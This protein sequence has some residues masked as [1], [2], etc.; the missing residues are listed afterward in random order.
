MS[1]DRPT[2]YEIKTDIENDFGSLFSFPTPLLPNS[3]AKSIA[4]IMTG[5]THMQYGYID[6]LAK[7]ALI[8]TATTKYLDQWGSIWAVVRNPASYAKGEVELTGVPFSICPA[9]TEFMREDGV[10]YTTDNL[11]SIGAGGTALTD[12]TCVDAGETGNM[13]ADTELTI[14]VSIPTLTDIAVVQEDVNSGAKEETD[15]A[16]RARI[17]NRVQETPQGGNKNDFE[18]WALTIDGVTRAFVFEN[19]NGAG[20]VGVT[21]VL[22]NESSIIPDS[23]KVDEVTDYIE[24]RRPLTCQVNVYAPVLKTQDLEIDLFP[25]TVEV[26]Q[27]VEAEI[28]DLFLR[29]GGAGEVIKIT[30]LNAAISTAIGEKDHNLHLTGDI[31]VTQDEVI[32]LGTITWSDM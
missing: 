28:E 10:V 24:E 2:I 27:E 9:D 22:D 8:T 5:A 30:E 21:F 14:V 12:I 16:L 6:Q 19:P 17:L 20:T 4:A 29:E 11:I 25:N 23:A 18:Q 7:N 1:L 32:E 31:G 26:Q 13:D 15:E 3:I